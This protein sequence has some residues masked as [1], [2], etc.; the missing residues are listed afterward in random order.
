MARPV[1]R[2]VPEA[3]GLVIAPAGTGYDVL[4]GSR[5][6]VVPGD[7]PV[8]GRRSF[9]AGRRLLA[10][11][12]ERPRDDVVLFLLSGGASALL[13]VP[14]DGVT[15]ADKT[16][17]GRF[18]LRAGAAIDTMNVV[19]KH[20]SAVKGGGFLRH[21]APRRV[22]TLALSD[23]PGDDLATIGSGPTV[24]D[25]ST[26]GGA[27]A[28]LRRLA[29]DGRGIPPRVLRR[30][31][32]GAAGRGPV[33]TLKPGDPLL[34]RASAV[35]AGANRV[36]LAAAAREAR[37]RGY[38]VATPALRLRGEASDAGRAIAAGL[39]RRPS[40]PTCILGGGETYVTVREAAGEGGRCQE[41]ALAAAAGLAGTG[42]SVLAAG[43][44]GIDGETDAAGAFVDGG[45]LRGRRA[46]AARA[47]VRH[48]SHAFFAGTGRTFRP[49]PT[50]TNVMDVLIALHP[51][52]ERP[53]CGP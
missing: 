7:H 36:A 44:D 46:A 49:G 27:L 19:R 52:A 22:L 2:L 21:A 1:A 45:T 50:G 17:L 38:V 6:R 28:A 11:L 13:A 8:P 40:A 10:A 30:L 48:D 16:A 34:R 4:A 3:A 14:A 20:V 37:R 25:P 31:A 15:A 47:L 29:P 41:L 23:V 12:A 35:V 43:T 18:L 51:G 39:P 5:I 24:A 33:E 42:W 32:D 26:Y 9:A 53:P